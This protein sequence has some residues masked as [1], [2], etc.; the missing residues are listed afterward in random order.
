MKALIGAFNQEK[1]LVEAFSVIV[2]P[3]VEPMYS[4]TALVLN[5]LPARVL[6]LSTKMLNC[7]CLGFSMYLHDN[8]CICPRPQIVPRGGGRHGGGQEPEMKVTMMMMIM[9]VIIMVIMMMMKVTGGPI[10]Y[11][12]AGSAVT[13]ECA[14]SGLDEKWRRRPLRLRQPALPLPA[15]RAADG[16]GELHVRG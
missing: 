7:L 11:A 8:G 10:I 1:A 9:I 13:L 4:F 6:H 15:A 16:H 2:Q 12:R 3:V 5:C 14:V